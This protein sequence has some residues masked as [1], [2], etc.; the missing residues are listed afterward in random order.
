L[1]LPAA[2]ERNANL[3]VIFAVFQRSYS[4]PLTPDN[5]NSKLVPFQLFGTNLNLAFDPG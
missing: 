4:S 2:L 1:H 3:R 5:R